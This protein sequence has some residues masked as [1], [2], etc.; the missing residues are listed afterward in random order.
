MT[1]PLIVRAVEAERARTER[2]SIVRSELRCP[3]SVWDGAADQARAAGL[4]IN[5]FWV[6]VMREALDED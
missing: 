6:A 1:T 3:E 2:E 4:T 5:A